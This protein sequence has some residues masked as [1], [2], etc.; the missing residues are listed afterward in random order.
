MRF[1]VQGAGGCDEVT[2]G[3]DGTKEITLGGER[4]GEGLR[5]GG[6][7]LGSAVAKIIFPTDN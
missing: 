6:W 4:G 3:E 5:N 2:V 1:S 7:C